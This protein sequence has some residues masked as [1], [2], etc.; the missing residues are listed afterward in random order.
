MSHQVNYLRE[1][2][3]TEACRCIKLT[4]LR[5]SLVGFRIPNIEQLFRTQIEEYWGHEF[6][7]LVLGYNQNVLIN[8]IF[9]KIQNGQLYYCQPFHCPTSV[10]CPGL[11]WKVEYTNSNHGIMP[12]F[13]NIWVAYMDSDLDNTCQGGVPSFLMLY[14]GCTPPNWIH[15][16]P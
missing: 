12:K 5:D 4:A 7:G 15:L 3:V 8:I 10:E 11:D 1:T 9:I 2:Q 13:H 16:F 6:S 14:F